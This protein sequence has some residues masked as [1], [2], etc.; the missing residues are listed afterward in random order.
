[1]SQ[2]SQVLA[3]FGVFL[4]VGMSGGV[5][6]AADGLRPAVREQLFLS[7]HPARR[8]PEHHLRRER[9]PHAERTVPVGFLITLVF[10]AVFLL[11]GTPWVYFV[12]R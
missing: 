8:K 2:S 12:T 6:A 5:P 10:L 3:L 11:I 1:M 4:E 7:D 9:L